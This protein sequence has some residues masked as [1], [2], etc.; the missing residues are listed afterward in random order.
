[1]EKF[2]VVGGKKLKGKVSVSG[3]KNVALK[4]I[5]AACLTSDEVII[6]NVPLISDFF[7]MTDIVKE[8]GGDVKIEDHKVY[9]RVKEIK[10]TKISLEKAAEIRTSSMFLA[11]LLARK[12]VAVIPNPGGCRIGA[13]PI[14]RVIDGFKKMGVNIV[15]KSRDG[16]FHANTSIEG[17]KLKG[18]EYEFEKNTHTGTEILILAAVTANRRTVLKNAAQEPEIDELVNLLNK[19][20][21]KIKRT[22]PRVIVIDGVEKL[23]GTNFI[24]GPDRNEVV[25]FAI[26]AVLT[27]GDIFVKNADKA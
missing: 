23:H 12:G 15:Y 8:L 16:Y 26:A 2:I 22:E 4:A 19:M 24:I 7:V 5:V 10:N 18:A 6:E 1:M 25:T 14:D 9:I 20:G 3:A 17:N 11:P 27:N 13:R 21:A